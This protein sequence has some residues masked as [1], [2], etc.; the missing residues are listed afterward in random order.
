MA[1]MSS[2]LHPLGEIEQ[3]RDG[4]LPTAT[5]AEDERQITSLDP[6][7]QGRV[8]YAQEP[9]RQALRNRF[10]ELALQLGTD[11]GDVR[12]PSGAVL[13]PAEASN[14]LQTL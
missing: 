10:A 2:T 13:S 14:L 12:I 11:G 1:V 4:N 7:L 5:R 8:A 9:G 3:A 6:A